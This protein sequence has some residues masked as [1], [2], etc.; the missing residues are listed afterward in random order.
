MG[1]S[2]IDAGSRAGQTSLRSSRN[3]R[4]TGISISYRTEAGWWNL[5]RAHDGAIEPMAEMDAEFGRPQWQFGVHLRV[6]SPP[7]A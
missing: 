5:Y 4:P 7:I 3:G 2:E 1:Q 6:P